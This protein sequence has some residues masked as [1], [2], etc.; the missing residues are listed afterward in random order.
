MKLSLRLLKESVPDFPSVYSENLADA[1]SICLDDQ[2]H[3]SPTTMQVSVTF[4]VKTD[5]GVPRKTSFASF[6]RYP[7]GLVY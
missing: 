6:S 5:W 3:K 4:P 7:A 2:G 1:G